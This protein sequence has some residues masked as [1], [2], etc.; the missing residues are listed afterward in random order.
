MIISGAHT[1]EQDILKKKESCPHFLRQV[2]TTR[3]R[4]SQPSMA[5]PLLF[6]EAAFWGPVTSSIDWCEPNYQQ[7]RFI[8]EPLNTVSNLSFVLFGILGAIHEANQRSKRSYVIL[9]SIIACIGLGS[10]LFHGKLVIHF[11]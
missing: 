3:H 7:S 9:H 11:T 8:A 4:S 5:P 1:Q 2:E 10:M 6:Q